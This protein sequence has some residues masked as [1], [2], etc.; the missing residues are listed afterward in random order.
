MV[1]SV[2]QYTAFS[3]CYLFSKRH[4]FYCKRGNAILFT[5]IRKVRLLLKILQQLDCSPQHDV[6]FIIPNLTKSE[7]EGGKYLFLNQ[8]YDDTSPSSTVPL[9]YLVLVQLTKNFF[10]ICGNWTFIILLSR[11]GKWLLSWP[12]R[13]FNIILPF[14]FRFWK[15]S[16]SFRP[17]H[18]ILACSP[19]YVVNTPSISSSLIWSP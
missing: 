12:I 18:P 7:N 17:Y 9:E 4:R 8:T 1:W 11:T 19:P 3:I 13:T 2:T 5:P 6:R 16:L 10:A 14:M 15:K